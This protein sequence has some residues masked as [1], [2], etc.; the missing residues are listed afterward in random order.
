ML[1]GKVKSST[2]F[3]DQKFIKTF[4]FNVW[5]RIDVY[6]FG[7]QSLPSD[8]ILTRAPSHFNMLETFNLLR[9]CTISS[10]RSNQLHTN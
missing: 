10:S 4:H 8:S 1:S 9:S 7:L 3:V 5:N 2:K 6:V